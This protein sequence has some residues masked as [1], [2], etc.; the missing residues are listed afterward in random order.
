MLILILKKISNPIQ[1]EKV[2]VID[3]D[4]LKNNKY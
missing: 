1:L 3:S 2:H 4:N